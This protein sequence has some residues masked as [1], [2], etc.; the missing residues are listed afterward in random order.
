MYMQ[1]SQIALL[2]LK[3]AEGYLGGH[4]RFM[5]SVMSLAGSTKS[6]KS[7]WYVVRKFQNNGW[8]DKNDSGYYLLQKGREELLRQFPLMEWRKHSWDGKWR[9]VMYDLPENIKPKRD[10]L[11]N[12][13]KRLG[14][15]RW[16]MSVWISPHPVSEK[17][18][19]IITES[20]LEQYC[21]VHES[22]RVT[23]QSDKKFADQIWNLSKLNQKYYELLNQ[24]I[25]FQNQRQVFEMLMDDPML[26][27]ELLPHDWQW[28]NIMNKLTLN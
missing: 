16:Q 5:S 26:P 12:W 11:R 9:V 8:I 15:G 7:Y 4:K 20:G 2:L 10:L 25:S 28:D 6:Q 13:L 1:T 19:Q 3:M 18:H 22:I 17:I 21:S 23:G 24:P 14:F 27:A